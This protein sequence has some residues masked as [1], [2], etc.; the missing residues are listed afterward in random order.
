M[1][2]I[3]HEKFA[4]RNNP[5]IVNSEIIN[6]HETFFIQNSPQNRPSLYWSI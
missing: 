4:I 5:F 2:K 6:T 3:L 1:Q